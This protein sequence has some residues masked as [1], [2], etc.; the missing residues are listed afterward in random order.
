MIRRA[1]KEDVPRLLFMGEQFMTEYYADTLSFNAERMEALFEGLIE[2]PS[3]FLLVSEH[4]DSAVGAI[5]L[6]VYDH[7]FTGQA[8]A[9]ELFWWVD[10]GSRGGIDGMRL[11]RHAEKWVASNKIAWMHMVAPNDRLK[12]FYK[13]LGYSELETHFYKKAVSV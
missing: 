2:N 11:L 3:G 13:R 8:C 4:N 12:S 1:V 9:S 10:P 6:L 5:G 7:P